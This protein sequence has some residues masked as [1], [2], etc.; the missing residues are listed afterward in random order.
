M[1]YEKKLMAMKSLVK[2]TAVVQEAKEI[3][4]KPPAP[5]YEKRWLTTGME[6]IENDLGIVYKRV[7]H[8]PLEM[9]HGDFRL[10]DIKQKLLKWSEADYAHPLSPES[11]K[12]LFFDTETT[13]LKGA[14]AVIFLIGLLELT[15]DEF[16]MTQYVLPNPDHEAAFLYASGLWKEGLTLVTYNG[17]SFDFPQLQTRWSLHR[18]QLPPLPVPHQ[19]DLLHGS[20]RIWKGQMDSFK[21]A[22]VEKMQ[23]GFHR[24]DDI[25]GHMAPIIYQDA[26]KNGR[27][28]ILMKVMWHNEW[29]ILSL[30]T[31]FSLSSDIIMEEESQQNAQVATNIAKWFQ[32]LGLTDHSYKELQRIAETYGS[33]YPLTHYHLG[34]LLK[35]NKEYERAVQSFE[36][37]SLYG[38]GREQLLA[39][40]E[41]AKLYEHQM[42]NF[43]LAY[44]SIISAKT[45]L[46]QPNDFTKRFFD[47]MT[48]S[49]AKREIRITRK[50]FPGQ[51]QEATREE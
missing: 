47:R 48:K 50:L 14:G 9:M 21:L 11:G 19:I 15:S 46:E 30:V 20:R 10:G 18:N 13:G 26:V 25:P 12:L 7:V 22:E 34:L 32:D 31:L 3:F 8:Y 2:K 16:V 38:S 36:I 43:Q 45:L 6:K 1:S 35:R 33:S 41:L 42:K 51:A 28:E 37:V 27:A 4:T 5:L 29:D 39:F 24:K 23:L 44:E 40:E 49:L 17:K